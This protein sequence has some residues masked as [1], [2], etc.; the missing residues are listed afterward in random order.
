MLTFGV[1]YPAERHDAEQIREDVRLMQKARVGLVRLGARAWSHFEPEAGRY[2]TAWLDAAL[3]V[4]QE[5]DISVLLTPPVTSPPLWAFSR[6]PHILR[7][8]PGG[9]PVPISAP[10]P[11]CL[12][13]PEYVML[14]QQVTRALASHTAGRESIAGWYLPAADSAAR[15][16]C[17]HCGKAFRDWLLKRY[18]D[19]DVLNDTWDTADDG[20]VYRS[21]A[22]VGLPAAE[23]PVNSGQALDCARFHAE[24]WAG[25]HRGL[26]DTIREFFAE[27]PITL[28]APR[29]GAP[30]DPALLADN[31]DLFAESPST[32]AA[33]AV[34]AALNHAYLRGLKRRSFLAG[35]S[36]CIATGTGHDHTVPGE[37]R[38]QA[39]QAVA[40]GANGVC[41][42]EWR[43]VR[44]GMRRGLPGLLEMGGT[45]G[46]R[47]KEARK[48]GQEFAELGEWVVHTRVKAK[49]ALLYSP[50]SAWDG[51]GAYQH[52][53]HSLFSAVHRR[54]LSC[55]VIGPTADLTGYKA[56]L[57][58]SLSIVDETLAARLTEFV[59]D[60]GTLVLTAGGGAHTSTGAL[61]DGPAP[62]LLSELVGA[63][64]REV[65]PQR[66][67]QTQVITF[68]RGRLIARD[69]AIG[70][71]AEVLE[72]HGAQSLAEY[73]TPGIA[74]KS[75]VVRNESGKGRAFYLGVRLEGECL[76]A[77][78]DEILPEPPVKDLPGPVEAAVRTDGKE[79]R[80][81]FLL[82]HLPGRSE[83][84]L[85]HA[86]RDVLS[87]RDAGPVLHLSGYGVVGLEW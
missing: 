63:T 2:R 10:A 44:A 15:C 60:G 5:A 69:F 62:G 52:A 74:G 84:R 6:H 1:V 33:D 54:K 24:A 68:A 50:E 45:P 37:A 30:V 66:R 85:E 64:V 55:D 31:V 58:P 9:G 19:T 48:T 51:G 25:F 29:L 8:T 34:S 59:R 4:F 26:R 35:Q 71:W 43:T 12:N 80:V 81:L 21:W 42:A 57:A 27:T 73:R 75:A 32:P 7:H 70:G 47:S 87:K 11:C 18:G 82:N 67:G 76:D 3:T 38:L 79:R 65:R 72:C 36:L 17:E 83:I 56:L 16:A 61:V 13:A 14:A 86:R 49:A 23:G 46:L 40:N 78:L 41:Y 77:V 53:V 20:V 39:W 22:E 28:E